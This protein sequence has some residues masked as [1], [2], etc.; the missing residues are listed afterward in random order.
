M[1]L[2][3]VSKHDISNHAVHPWFDGDKVYPQP[4][5]VHIRDD[6]NFISVKDGNLG[7]TLYYLYDE[8]K[9]YYE[10]L[11]DCSFFIKS[12]L[13]EQIRKPAQWEQVLKELKTNDIQF[14]ISQMNAD[15][16]IINFKNGILDIQ[17]GSIRPHTP[18]ILST[19]QI[20]CDYRPELT[21]KD[22]P[23]FSG[24]LDDITLGEEELK[25]IILEY[26]GA[27]ISNVKGYKYKKLIIFNGAGNTGKSLLRE[28][29]FRLVGE[30]NCHSISMWQLNSRFGPAQIYGKRLVG[31]GELEAV[32]LNE[33]NIIKEL[34]GGDSLNAEF[35]GKDGFSFK[36]GGFLWFNC[37]QLPSFRG[38]QGEH[39]YE[40]FIIVPCQNVIPVEKRDTH[41]YEKM[42]AEKEAIVSTAVK[43]FRKTVKQ[44]YFTEGPIISAARRD[45]K[46]K[47]NSLF[48]F[49]DSQCVMGQ[50]STKRSFIFNTY[51]SWC[52][53]NHIDNVLGKKE[54]S[55]ILE[56]DFGMSL[57]KNQGEYYYPI[58]VKKF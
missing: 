20:P 39:V 47:T 51:K 8:D 3:N 44:G 30:Q 14:D 16:S 53:D 42:L 32:N 34:T 38:D 49:I 18:R 21:L 28:L 35:K 1:Y 12:H 37:N 36:Y 22:A 48:E 57:Q 15:E 6:H 52:R 27:V 17:S 25:T 26:M 46:Y 54:I 9:G 23:N 31:S 5:H 4:L 29:A 33:I 2:K 7:C 10:Q 24:F 40:R 41:L 19:V 58:T 43:Y 45:Y 13:P 11:N 55:L 50:G 56:R